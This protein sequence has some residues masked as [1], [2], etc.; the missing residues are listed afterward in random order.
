MKPKD[1]S[2]VRQHIANAKRAL[3]EAEDLLRELTQ[4]NTQTSDTSTAGAPYPFKNSNSSGPYRASSFQR[5]VGTSGF[6]KPSRITG[7][8]AGRSKRSR[9]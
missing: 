7:G 1:I 4:P 8:K 6:E 2:L 5:R 3:F 9:R